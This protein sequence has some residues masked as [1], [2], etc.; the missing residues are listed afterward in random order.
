MYRQSCILILTLLIVYWG[1]AS[2]FW[3]NSEFGKRR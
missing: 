2:L 3:F 1:E